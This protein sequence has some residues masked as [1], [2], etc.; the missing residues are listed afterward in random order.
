MV[1]RTL[2]RRVID[3]TLKISIRYRSYLIVMAIDLLSFCASYFSRANWNV[4]MLE[5]IELSRWECTRNGRG[6]KLI[7]SNADMNR[8]DCIVGLSNNIVS[9]CWGSCGLEELLCSNSWGHRSATNGGK[10]H[11]KFF[12]NQCRLSVIIWV[13][14]LGMSVGRICGDG[15]GCLVAERYEWEKDG[16]R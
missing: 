15:I 11:H 10:S 3:F 16:G 7:Q 4:K 14:E 12:R 6:I 1:W 2:A 8:A 9:G 5:L 13:L